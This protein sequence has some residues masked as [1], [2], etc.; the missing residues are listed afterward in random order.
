M[1]ELSMSFFFLPFSCSL[2]CFHVFS[3]LVCFFLFRP[4][5]SGYLLVLYTPYSVGPNFG[6]IFLFPIT[7]LPSFPFYDFFFI[8]RYF[9]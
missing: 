2:P 5:P 4:L 8:M 6:S 3:F 9:V 7:P 1:E